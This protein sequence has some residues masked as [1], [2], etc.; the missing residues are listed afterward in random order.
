VPSQRAQLSR[1]RERQR[2]CER[3]RERQRDRETERQRDR[4]TERQRAH[5]AAT[6]PGKNVSMISL[7]TSTVVVTPIARNSAPFMML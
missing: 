2:V 3:D 4:E 5:G 7:K 1:D 6:Y